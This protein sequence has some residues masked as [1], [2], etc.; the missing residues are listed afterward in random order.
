[1][2]HVN[3]LAS[4]LPGPSSQPGATEAELKQ[5][6][7][8]KT[9]MAAHEIVTQKLYKAKAAS[10]EAYFKSVWKIS[11]AQVYRFL[12]CAT[13]LTVGFHMGMRYFWFR[14][15]TFCATGKTGS[16]VPRDPGPETPFLSFARL[17]SRTLPQ[18]STSRI[19]HKYLPT[20]VCADP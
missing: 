18:N 7:F 5:E 13:V 11:R 16:P 19:S 10:L 1:M 2:L 14:D 9:V 17:P 4:A 8:R 12:D 15:L 20:N 6:R 3:T